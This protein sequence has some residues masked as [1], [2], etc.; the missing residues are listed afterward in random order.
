MIARDRE[1]EVY[2]SIRQIWLQGISDCRKAISRRSI[3]EANYDKYVEDIG[4]KIVIDTVNALYH[5]LVD[6][7]EA[8]LKTEADKYYDETYLPNIKEI[9][10]SGGES[11]SNYYRMAEEAI[12]LY[13]HIIQT[14]NKYGMLFESQPEGYSNVEMKS[15]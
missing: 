13:H 15:L 4:S 9:W 10:K 1:A 7:G 11:H 5:S 6:Y 14:L 3:P 2:V 8:L 12:D